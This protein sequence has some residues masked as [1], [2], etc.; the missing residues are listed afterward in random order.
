MSENKLLVVIAGPTAVGKTDLCVQLAQRFDT[1]VVSAD[2]RQFY[3]ELSIGTAKPSI[4]EMQ[5]VRHH[6]V[7][8]MSIHDYFSVGDYEQEC[9]G[10]L[11]GVFRDKSIAILTGGSGLFLKVVID[12]IDD[13]PDAPLEIR[14]KL[15]KQYESEGIESLLGLLQSLDL[16]YYQEVDKQNPQRVIRALEVCIDT[17]KPFSSF[18]NQTKVKRPFDILKIALD[19]PRDELYAR[20][21]TRV[22][23][24]LKAGLVE[25]ALQYID[26]REHYAL[27]TVGYKE[28]FEWKDGLYDY[29]EMVRLIKRNT[30]RYAKRQLTWFRNQ[31][32]FRWFNPADFESIEDT[33]QQKTR[34]IL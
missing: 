10:V 2:S 31:D 11:E 3:Q 1:E 13:M 23:V 22:D 4:A 16:A 21:D 14:E 34:E 8:S 19:R 29:S 28:I 15:T 33:I 20:I 6:F 27:R 17:G 7:G 25:E 30:R 9:L 12:G 26:F 18:R 32:D 24:M 5:G